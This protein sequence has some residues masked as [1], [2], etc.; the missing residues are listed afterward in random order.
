MSQPEPPSPENAGATAAEPDE[1]QHLRMIEAVLFAAEE[2]LTLGEIAARLPEGVD[3]ARHMETLQASYQ[4]RGINLVRRGERY[5]FQ[6]APDLGF[7]I[8]QDVDE[9]RSLSRAGMETLAIIAY[10]QPVTRAEIEEIRGVGLSKGTLDTLLEAG[11]VRPRGRKRTPGRPV[12]YATTDAFLAHF[13]LESLEDLP[14]L[15]ELKA[16]GLLDSVDE[17]L[18]RME[19]QTAAGTGEEGEAPRPESEPA[20]DFAEDEPQDSDAEPGRAGDEGEDEEIGEGGDLGE[21]EDG[22]ETDPPEAGDEPTR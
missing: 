6:T 4:N 9:I 11:W 18:S 22:A 12:M 5:L 8:R 15:G 7:L 21:P 10:H 20:F 1:S 2:P 13:G 16:A 14:G 19:E 17:A 3:I